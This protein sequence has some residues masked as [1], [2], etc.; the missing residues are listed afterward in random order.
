MSISLSKFGGSK[1]SRVENAHRCETAYFLTVKVWKINHDSITDRA[2][3]MVYHLFGL[4]SVAGPVIQATGRMDFE[5]GLR[6]ATTL[7]VS[8]G[9]HSIR[10]SPEVS[11]AGP[12]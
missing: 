9:L 7:E 5:D 6:I 11:M 8:T 12:N 1:L 3:P 10:T 2:I 4:G